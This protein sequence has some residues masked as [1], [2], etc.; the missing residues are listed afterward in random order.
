MLNSLIKIKCM[1]AKLRLSSR[2]S[3]KIIKQRQD[4]SFI[5][6]NISSSQRDCGIET[7]L[8]Q[9]MKDKG[10]HRGQ[11]QRRGLELLVIGIVMS[12]YWR[13]LNSTKKSQ[14]DLCLQCMNSKES[15]PVLRNWNWTELFV[16]LA[17]TK[18]VK[19]YFISICL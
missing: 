11:S 16:A 14:V 1:V 8:I 9:S 2:C 7:V 3:V 4:I 17:P 10:G 12:R 6:H 13:T 19:H 5:I 18:K 15:K